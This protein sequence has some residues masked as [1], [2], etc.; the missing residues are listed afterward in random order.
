MMTGIEPLNGREMLEAELMGL[1][2]NAGRDLS[3]ERAEE[4]TLQAKE[5]KVVKANEDAKFS[6]EAYLES[7]AELEDIAPYQ[8]DVYDREVPPTVVPL[9]LDSFA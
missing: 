3:K 2:S 9:T 1:P 8:G 6:L 5:E 4:R 7:Y